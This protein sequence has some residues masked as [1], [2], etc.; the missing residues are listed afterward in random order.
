MKRI[1]CMCP[2]P[3]S[4]TDDTDHFDIGFAVSDPY[5]AYAVPIY[6]EEGTRFF[7]LHVSRPETIEKSAKGERQQITWTTL[8]ETS[9]ALMESIGYSDLGGV[10]LALPM[11]TQKF[12]QC[13]NTFDGLHLNGVRD[14]MR[15]IVRNY[16]GKDIR[17]FNLQCYVQDRLTWEEAKEMAKN[18]PEIW[19]EV[20]FESKH[21]ASLNACVALNSFLY[22]HNG[23]GWPNTF[24]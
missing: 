23:G 24:G 17:Q 1:L 22:R 7:E 14:S 9:Q 3:M 21:V 12:D 4:F 8:P 13:R 18:E 11:K 6:P 19:E 20:D 5:L 2:V 15:Q 16:Q 10:A